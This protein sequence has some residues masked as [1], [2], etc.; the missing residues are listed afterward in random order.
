MNESICS[1]ESLYS[2]IVI[3]ADIRRSVFSIWCTIV[4]LLCSVDLDGAVSDRGRRI[5]CEGSYRTQRANGDGASKKA[6]D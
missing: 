5:S 2:G 1:F 3:I 4:F 6:T